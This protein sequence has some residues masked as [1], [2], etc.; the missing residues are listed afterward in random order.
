MLIVKAC[1]DNM[2]KGGFEAMHDVVV[3]HRLVGRHLVA[4]LRVVVQISVEILLVDLC[5]IMGQN[6]LS[7][8]G[9]RVS[10][11]ICESVFVPGALGWASR[12]EAP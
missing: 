12:P 11:G 3:D 8:I 1:G 4:K 6:A 2:V 10:Q 7:I 5:D 9:L